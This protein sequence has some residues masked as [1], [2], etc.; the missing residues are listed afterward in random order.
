MDYNGLL[1]TQMNQHFFYARACVFPKPSIKF[2]KL[3][4]AI[5]KL[6]FTFVLWNLLFCFFLFILQIFLSLFSFLEYH[7]LRAL[8]PTT[9]KHWGISLERVLKVNCLV[10]GYGVS[11]FK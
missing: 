6:R 4:I 9:L 1:W 7:A 2:Q 10:S 8:I 5:A 3:N 11:K